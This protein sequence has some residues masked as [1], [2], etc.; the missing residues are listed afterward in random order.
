[1]ERDEVKS[2]RLLELARERR[3]IDDAKSQLTRDEEQLNRDLSELAGVR[4]GDRVTRGNGAQV[5]IRTIH[6][7][8]E[9]GPD[10]AI[11]GC[12]LVARGAGHTLRRDGEPSQ[13]HRNIPWHQSYNDIYLTNDEAHSIWHASPN[14]KTPQ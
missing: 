3:R 1:M 2:A 8:I 9:H 5:V 14:P 6:A 10:D 13:L 12:W 11:I 4:K 7:H